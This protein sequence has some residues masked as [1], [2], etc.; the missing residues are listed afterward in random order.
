M[1]SEALNIGFRALGMDDLPMLK[2]W[3]ARPHWQEWW[4]DPDEEVQLL[5]DKVDG[6]SD[7]RPFLVLLD[8]APIGYVQYW[9][10]ADARK[11]EAEDHPWL[12]ELDE[13]GVGVDISIADAGSLSR[14]IGSASL[15]AFVELL[16]S[17]GHTEITIDPEKAN[18]RA[19]R[20]YE[21]AGF[22]HHPRT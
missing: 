13:N 16:I 20:A 15:R 2:T 10:V 22:W 8:G 21:K 18:K 14:G 6:R 1:P 5:S 19:V 17:Q 11:S 12:L 3:I 7:T 9:Y 4:G